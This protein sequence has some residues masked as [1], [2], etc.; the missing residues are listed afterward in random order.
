MAG[1]FLSWGLSMLHGMDKMIWWGVVIQIVGVAGGTALAAFAPAGGPAIIFVPQ[2]VTGF[3][4]GVMLPNAIAGAISVR[5][6]AAGNAARFPGRIPMMGGAPLLQLGGL[7]LAH[8][9]TGL[10]HALLLGGL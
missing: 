1:N 8:A 10:S 4:N 3:G 9:T 7:V 6:Q 5:P 2:L